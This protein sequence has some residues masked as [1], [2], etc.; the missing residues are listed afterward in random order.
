MRESLGAALL[1]DGQA[2]AAEK[3]FREDLDRNPR[4]PR[5][6]LR[7]RREPEG[8]GK[9][10]RR[11]VG[12]GAVRDRLEARGHE[13]HASG[14][15][16]MSR[17]PEEIAGLYAY[18]RWANGRTLEACAALSPE[19]LEKEVGGSFV[20]VL[21]TLT[22]VIGAE[23]VWLERWHGRSPKALPTSSSWSTG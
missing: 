13:D 20:S 7:P 9:N 19:E 15:S 23:W 8:A 2:A 18:N 6:L 10:G 16:E 22:H 3:V 21:G 4:N 1:A 11:G 17:S 5:S 12:A 14:T